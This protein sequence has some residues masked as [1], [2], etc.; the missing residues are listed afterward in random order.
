[1]TIFIQYLK[2]IAFYTQTMSRKTKRAVRKVFEYL[3]PSG[4]KSDALS[5]RTRKAITFIMTFLIGC[6]PLYANLIPIESIDEVGE[7]VRDLRTRGIRPEEIGM[8][9]DFHGVVTDQPHHESI[10]TLKGNIKNTLDY[11]S[12]ERMP[13][14]LATAW[15]NFTE[16]VKGVKSLELSGYFDIEDDLEA[17][18]NKYVVGKDGSLIIKGY[19]NGRVVALK[20]ADYKGEDRFFRQKVYALEVTHPGAVFKYLIVVD[21]DRGNLKII[22]RDF[23]STVY[24]AQGCELILFH[25][26]SKEESTPIKNRWTGGPPSPDFERVPL[27]STLLIGGLL[28]PDFK[29]RDAEISPRSSEDVV[30]DESDEFTASED[31]V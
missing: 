17:H 12:Q 7:H 16:I 14:A 18:L 19:K 4:P 2:P 29:G 27:S 23:P 24:A 1:M 11:F 5:R 10:L 31:S 6:H 25:L 13:V 15:T 30:N 28:H 20:Y 9:L 21:D 22:K 26:T 8:I 3:S